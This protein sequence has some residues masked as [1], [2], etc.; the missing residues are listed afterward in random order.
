MWCDVG[1][2]AREG[3]HFS[4]SKNA[5]LLNF[6]LFCIIQLADKFLPMLAFKPGI[7][8]VGSDRYA[9]CATTTAR[10]MVNLKFQSIYEICKE[11]KFWDEP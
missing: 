1:G 9:N 3:M 6:C 4:Q 7:S 5:R 11:P 10:E 2:G 8:G